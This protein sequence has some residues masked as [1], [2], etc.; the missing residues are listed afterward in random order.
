MTIIY[1]SRTRARVGQECVQVALLTV[2]PFHTPPSGQDY[3]VSVPLT[4]RL[5]AYGRIPRPLF[6]RDCFTMLQKRNLFV[7][8]FSLYSSCQQL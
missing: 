2:Y 1:I 4:P 6:L 7:F 5:T 3:T 8:T